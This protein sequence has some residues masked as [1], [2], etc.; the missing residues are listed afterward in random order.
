MPRPDADLLFQLAQRDPAGS[1]G[2]DDEPE[3]AFAGIRALR[4]MADFCESYQVRWLRRAGDGWAH[5]VTW[6]GVS[7]Q[8][9]HK[10]HA[11]TVDQADD[12]PESK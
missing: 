9:L 3:L 6:A 7:A 4:S 11:H 1:L 5:I 8:A 10:K 12:H 2:L